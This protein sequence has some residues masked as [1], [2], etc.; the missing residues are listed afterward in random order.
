MGLE[1]PCFSKRPADLL[2]KVEVDKIDDVV[3][4]HSQSHILK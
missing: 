2:F 4:V 3:V 1:V